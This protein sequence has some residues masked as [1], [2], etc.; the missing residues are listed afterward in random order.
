MPGKHA[1]PGAGKR[2]TDLLDNG[3]GE[4]LTHGAVD[5]EGEDADADAD[6]YRRRWWWWM[7]VAEGGRRS[8]VEME[9][10]A[11]GSCW[12]WWSRLRRGPR[13]RDEGG[14]GR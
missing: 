7:T 13:D 11:A 2:L 4:R 5:G 8:W 12:L 9:K 10:L 3:F 14:D 1:G 6:G